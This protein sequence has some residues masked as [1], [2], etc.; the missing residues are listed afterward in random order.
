MT[1]FIT[2][3]EIQENTSEKSETKFLYYLSEEKEIK[4]P[5]GVSFNNTPE[6]WDNVLLIS[7]DYTKEGLDLMYAYDNQ[8]ILGSGFLY[9]G[10]YKRKLT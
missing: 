5:D 3:Q 6:D 2:L 4:V 9:L 8:D 1:K 7:H 10:Y